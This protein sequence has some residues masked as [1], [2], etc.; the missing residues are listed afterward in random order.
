MN[1]E[2]PSSQQPQNVY[3]TVR[4]SFTSKAILTLILYFVLYI[5]GLIAN[6]VFWNEA[7][8]IK[9]RTGDAPEG[10]GCLASML[11]LQA[12]SVGLFCIIFMIAMI[13]G[14]GR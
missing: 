6:F 10:Y 12:I 11:I 7:R 5:P 1:P 14:G 2:R 9:E 4:V 13:S 3:L 8:R